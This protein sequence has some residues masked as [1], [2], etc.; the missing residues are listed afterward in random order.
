VLTWRKRD[1]EYTDFYMV[2]RLEGQVVDFKRS[3]DFC[4]KLD[5]LEDE[6]KFRNLYL[7]F[8][9]YQIEARMA[10]NGLGNDSHST[11]V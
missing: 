10:K 9:F 1:T 6:L 5:R 2:P 3:Q 11:P 8:E 4:A 7:T